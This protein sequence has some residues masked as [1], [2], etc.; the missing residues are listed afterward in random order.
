MGK[1][2]MKMKK[3]FLGVV[4]AAA[5]LTASCGQEKVRLFDGKTLD[6]WIAVLDTAAATAQEATFSVRDGVIHVTG[7]P[8]G[9]L[10]TEAS[11]S[12]YTLHLEWRW[13]GGEAVDGGIFNYLQE[14][15]KV[16]PTG[17]QCQMTP[18]GMGVLMGGIPMEGV[19][20]GERG[21]FVKPRLAD[22]SPERPVGEWNEMTF[23]CTGGHLEVT[24]NGAVVNEADC[25]A[26]RGFIGFQSEGGAME[27][28]N[29]YL[30]KE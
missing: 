29:L 23:R 12:D 16:W 17:V 27:F 13:A 6:G 4:L 14:G 10:R 3:H 1:Q 22:S 28:R 11:Y 26:D 7:Q 2:R 19:D 20:G 18:E 8:F 9:Y 15:D 25:A 30:V 24:L 21:F 5:V